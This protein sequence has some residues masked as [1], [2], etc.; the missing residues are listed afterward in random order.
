MEK[1]FKAK[2]SGVVQGVGF[3]P[4]VY[5]LA[6][7]RQLKGFVFNTTEGVTL[8]VEGREED[9]EGFF[10]DLLRYKPPLAR[11]VEIEREEVTPKSY[12][13]FTILE[14]DKAMENS[15]LIPPD[16]A[17]CDD[18]LRELMDPRDRRYLY[19][20]INCTNCG[21]RYTIICDLPY[22]RA[23][24]TMSE[25]QMCELCESEYHNPMDRRFHA[26]PNACPRCGPMVWL[27][28]KEGRPLE[29]KDPIGRAREIISQ[30]LIVGVKGLGG[31]HLVV[32]ATK[33]EAVL[34]LRERKGREEKP[35][36]I[37]VRDL[38]VLREA[39]VLNRR[40]ETLLLSQERPIVL[41][42]KRKGQ[43]L[44]AEGVSPKNRF[45]G[46]ML[47][48]APLYH[49]LLRD[50]LKAIVATSGNMSEE[51]IAKTNKEALDRLKDIA[52]FF[53]LHNREIHQRADDSVV[54]IV[55]GGTSFIRRSRGYAPMPIFLAP[56]L[57]GLP[58]ALGVGAELKNTFC[59]LRENQAFLSQ[60]IG[61]MENLETF[62]YFVS[63]LNALKGL[64]SI[65]P[66]V[67]GYDLHPLYLTTD[68]ALG[69][70][71]TKKVGIQHHHAH[72][73]SCMAENGEL[74]PVIGVAL[75]GTGYGDDGSIWGGEILISNLTSYRRLGHLEQVRMIS[76]D[77]TIR[78]PWKTAVALLIRSYGERAISIA[79][80]LFANLHELDLKLTFNAIEKGFNTVLCSSTGRLFD[81]I[82][83]LLGIR[84]KN[85]YEGQAPMELEMAQTRERTWPYELAIEKDGPRFILLTSPLV[86]GIL[87]DMKKGRS[88]GYCARRFHTSLIELLARGVEEASSSTGI[89]KVALSGGSF[90]NTTLL[91]GLKR[92]LTRAG[93]QVFTHTLAP[94]NDGGVS[95][96]QAVC[97]AATAGGMVHELP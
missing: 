2:I 19:P 29:V 24:T 40:E 11:I 69:L 75:D 14:S 36:A 61:D 79:R 9:I 59:L 23:N 80:E 67:I 96:G 55:A 31:F 54:K 84:M 42:R 53:L 83:A 97:A 65:E 27:A 48:Y 58:N 60:H 62:Q 95:L 86:E 90:Q 43:S 73:V 70:P 52:D 8:E 91:S 26:Q 10:E 32:D 21:P 74:G 22:D 30:G 49:L 51:P 15:A 94:A 37:M 7:K 16:M 63:A 64:L 93:F 82:A 39:C 68:Y 71:G 72:V 20:F 46:V 66:D 44:I 41:L 81:G 89:H 85:S 6:T 87:E 47:P 18:C 33:D 25:F 45:F 38:L 78:Y 3:R 35:F 17:T 1:A 4:F 50:P 28:D 13:L 88:R 76:S 12:G 56:E 92:R 5:Q 57:K 77:T 34:R